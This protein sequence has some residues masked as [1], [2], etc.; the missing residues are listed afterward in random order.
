MQAY[1]I[2]E[3]PAL[4]AAF[5]SAVCA[6]SFCLRVSGAVAPSAPALA[7]LSRMHRSAHNKSPG[8]AALSTGMRAE[9]G[10]IH[11]IIRPHRGLPATHTPVHV[12]A[13]MISSRTAGRPAVIRHA[14]S[15]IVAMS[16]MT[17]IVPS[18]S[19]GTGQPGRH[20]GDGKQDEL[21]LHDGYSSQWYGASMRRP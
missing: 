16:A 11:I 17:A 5:Q 4:A 3:P 19:A 10:Q 14:T 18:L 2:G 9:R 7:G 20:R 8:E 13:K 15:P 6:R 1:P 21:F 12:P